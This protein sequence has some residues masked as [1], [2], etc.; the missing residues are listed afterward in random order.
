MGAR[1]VMDRMTAAFVEQD[2]DAVEKL[3]AADAVAVA[4]ETGE[5]QGREA[6]VDYF[7][8]QW[9]A[10]PDGGYEHTAGYEAGNVA[11]D[12]GYWTGTNTGPLAMPSGEELPPTGRT[13]R[14]RACDI[15]T[16]D[17]GMITSHRF[18]YDQVDFMEQLGLLPELPF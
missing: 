16:V 10:F 1:E 13:L 2:F 4:P 12:E 5:I 9:A 14:L 11:I 8:Q 15:A 17:G 3:Y 18:Y 6:I 7:R